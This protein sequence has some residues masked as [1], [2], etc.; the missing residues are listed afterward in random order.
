MKRGILLAA[1]LFG[2]VALADAF[3]AGYRVG[4]SRGYCRNHGGQFCIPPIPPIC[5]IPA[6][7][8]NDYQG[9]YDRGYSDGL[10][11]P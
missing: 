5:P 9:G 11:I 2:G 7:G 3:C 6:V 1:L 8:E 10:L 4:Y